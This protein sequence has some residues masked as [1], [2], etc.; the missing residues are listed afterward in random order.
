[1]SVVRPSGNDTNMG[2]SL[3]TRDQETLTFVVGYI[4]N[5]GFSPS[6]REVAVGSGVSVAVAHYRLERLRDVGAVTWKPG[7]PRTLRVAHVSK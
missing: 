4:T 2:Y 6:V 5:N 3:S 7:S 1:M